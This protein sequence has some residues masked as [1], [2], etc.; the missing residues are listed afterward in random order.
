MSV[1]VMGMPSGRCRRPVISPPGSRVIGVD[2]SPIR[3]R[4][5]SALTGFQGL[6]ADGHHIPTLGNGSVD[7]ALSTMV[8]E[9]V[10]D[11]VGYVGELARIIR[12]GGWLYLTTVIRKRGAW[13][14]RKA[15]DGRRV[16]D[17]T[18]LREYSDADVVIRLIAAAGFVVTEQRLTRLVFPIAHPLIR[19]LHAKRPITDVQ[20]LFLKRSTGWLEWLALPIPR[21]RAIELLAQRAVAAAPPRGPRHVAG[22]E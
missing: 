14:F 15:P 18:H 5:F 6:L 12:P 9:H 11:D 1:A 16:L 17:P 7:L 13:Y 20:R 3:L 8:I 21:Y 22:D 2:I 4:R 19:W 10:S